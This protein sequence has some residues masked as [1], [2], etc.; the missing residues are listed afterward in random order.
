M[1]TYSAPQLHHAASIIRQVSALSNALV[2]Q[3][4]TALSRTLAA[5]SS[6][7]YCLPSDVVAAFRAMLSHRIKI[8][9][10]RMALCE[11][12][13]RAFLS[14]AHARNKPEPPSA[15]APVGEEEHKTREPSGGYLRRTR[16]WLPSGVDEEDLD[17][18]W[19]EDVYD[20]ESFSQEFR[21]WKEESE[22][23]KQRQ[24]T[25]GSSFRYW[26]AR[27]TFH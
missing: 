12:G 16:S 18:E 11:A 23:S 17:E 20:L 14:T 26:P 5:L 1:L 7:K 22:K 24:F 10:S 3:R 4:I 2:A 25:P 6:R 21:E 19:L 13:L 15:P 27:K 8:N 9:P